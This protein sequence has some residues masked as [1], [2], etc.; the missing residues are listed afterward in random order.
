MLVP[1]F[2]GHYSFHYY[3]ELVRLLISLLPHLVYKNLLWYTSSCWCFK[4]LILKNLWV[5]PGMLNTTMIY[6]PCS[7]D[8]GVTLTVSRFIDTAVIVYCLEENINYHYLF[9]TR[10]NCFTIYH[11]GSY[12]C[13]PTLKLNI[14]TS[15]SRLTNDSFLKITILISQLITY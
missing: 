2:H 12:S 15:T 8:P 13:L 5:L 6:S 4:P 14:A 3:Y 7:I 11:Y 1:S 9:L 10:L